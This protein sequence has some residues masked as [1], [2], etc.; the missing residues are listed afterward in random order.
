MSFY[1]II[2]QIV[3]AFSGIFAGL[4]AQW[5]SP[6]AA[7]QIIALLIVSCAMVCFFLLKSIRRLTHFSESPTERPEHA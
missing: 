3:P 2:S 1:S 5:L 4:V 6:E 7:L